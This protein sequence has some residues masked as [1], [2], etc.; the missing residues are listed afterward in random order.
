[1]KIPAREVDDYLSSVISWSNLILVAIILF[2]LISISTNSRLFKYVY[3]FETLKESSK[4]KDEFIS[5]GS[6]ELRAPLVLIKGNADLAASALAKGDVKK[7]SAFLEEIT[8]STKRLSDLVEDMLEV[9]RIEQGRMKFNFQ[10]IEPV[11]FIKD[12]LKQFQ[13][14]AG[15]KKLTLNFIEPDTQTAAARINVD[16]DRFKQILVN[17]TSNAIKYTLKGG[18]TV[19]LDRPKQNVLTI[20]FK[21][22]GLGMKAKKR[23]KLFQKFYRV[24]EAQTA[25]VTGTGLGLWITKMI[26]EAMKGEIMV[27][28]LEGVGTEFT[29][30][31]PVAPSKS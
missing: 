13:D 4:L 19:S 25:N 1:L 24:E 31:F 26:T 20:K 14:Q 22:T 27:D 18:L 6:H 17:L 3:Q 10:V 23:E 2:I 8:G 15:A 21:D 9:S 28:S 29:V 5:I 11:P 7:T 12:I 30:T 16:S